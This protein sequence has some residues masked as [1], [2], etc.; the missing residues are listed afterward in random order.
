[1]KGQLIQKKQTSMDGGD[2]ERVHVKGG[3]KR[4]REREKKKCT[5]RGEKRR[6][7]DP[8]ITYGQSGYWNN[9]ITSIVVVHIEG[10][11]L[12]DTWRDDETKNDTVSTGGWTY[13]AFRESTEWFVHQEIHPSL[14]ALAWA[15]QVEEFSYTAVVRT[16]NYKIRGVVGAGL[17][18]NQNVVVVLNV[19][20]VCVVEM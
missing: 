9:R 7:I 6:I 3:W 18:P 13:L 16:P 10:K 19:F 11:C 17:G 20:I 8:A 1:M 5:C 4:E 12:W 15:S 2:R 14:G